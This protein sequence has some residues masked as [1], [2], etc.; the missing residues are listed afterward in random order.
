MALESRNE[1]VH[2]DLSKAPVREENLVDTME[3]EVLPLIRETRR[4]VNGFLA[5]P[6]LPVFD[7][8]PPVDSDFGPDFEQRPR[9]GVL[10]IGGDGK[11][12][13]RIAGTFQI[14]GP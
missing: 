3:R 12:Y 2:Q 11:F 1:G 10:C 5:I 14:V 8:A 4:V 9:N 7:H 13:A 6:Q